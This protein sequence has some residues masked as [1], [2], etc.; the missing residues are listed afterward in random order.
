MSEYVADFETRNYSI[1][2]IDA[3]TSVWLW[4][5][6][7][8]DDPDNPQ[9]GYN[10][11]T[12]FDCLDSL[13]E[14]DNI[15]VWFHNLAFDGSFIVFH[16]LNNMRFSCVETD[17]VKAIGKGQFSVVISEMGQWYT[18][19]MRTERG[20]L[21]TFCD[22]VK[23]LNFKVAN[24]S[25]AFG[26]GECKGDI[27]YNKFRPFGYIADAEEVDYIRRD[28]SI[29]CKSISSFRKTCGV[30]GGTIASCAL[31]WYT[32]NLGNGDYKTGK[33][34][35]GS[36]YPQLTSEISNFVRRAYHGG[37]CYVMPDVKGKKQAALQK[38][39]RISEEGTR[40]AGVVLDVNSLYPSVMASDNLYPI[41]KP[42]IG[43]GAWSNLPDSKRKKFPCYFQEIK[44]AFEL[45]PGKLPT[46]QLKHDSDF[47]ATEYL[48]SSE[49][50]VK[51]FVLSGPDLERFFDSYEVE[52]LKY[53]QFCAFKGAKGRELFGSYVDYWMQLKKEGSKTKNKVL[54]TVA[55]LLL[56][57]LYGRFAKITTVRNKIPHLENEG[58]TYPLGEA[59]EL[60]SFSYIPIGAYITTYAREVTLKAASECYECFLYSDTDSIHLCL[61]IEEV[62]RRYPNFEIDDSKLGAWGIESEFYLEKPNTYEGA[63]RYLECVLP[64]YH[65]DYTVT[66][67]ELVDGKIVDIVDNVTKEGDHFHIACCGL[68][69]SCYSQVIN[70]IENG[71]NPLADGKQYD[72]KITKKMVKGGTIL[73][74][75]TFSMRQKFQ[76]FR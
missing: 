72:H 35:R 21:V 28:V 20:K 25:K 30:D 1:P 26:L 9:I 54:R 68:P 67:E 38:M 36:L 4:A 71:E 43:N 17:N 14:S 42:I 52:E 62:K 13:T 22:S 29:V 33:K 18:L 45:K 24:L 73:Q 61:P 51:S 16:L 2:E 11:E 23:L 47:L 48:T 75:S 56:N 59:H 55:K 46:L 53:V 57:S 19:T 32:S 63:K 27:D 41:G 50:K 31:R 70:Y 40:R 76:F 39:K 64:E 44:C 5:I 69:E 10:I 37:W 65:D 34:V 74:E 58:V 15:K 12:F 6:S 7:N 60:E 66:H 3:E 49:G 8:I